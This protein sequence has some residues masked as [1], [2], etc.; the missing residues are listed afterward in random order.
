MIPSLDN[1][2]KFANLSIK[3]PMGKFDANVSYIPGTAYGVDCFDV[4]GGYSNYGPRIDV[5]AP[6]SGI[7]SVLNSNAEYYDSNPTPDP[8]VAQLGLTDT[9]NNN[10]KKMAGTSMASPQICGMLACLAEK[11]PRMTQADARAYLKNMSPETVDYSNMYMSA[12]SLDF[13][14]NP[15]STK[16]IAFFHDTRF[17][18]LEVGGMQ[19]KPFP[20]DNEFQRPTSGA[21]YP[22]RKTINNAKNYTFV[23]SS[24]VERVNNGQTANVIITTIGVA[25]GTLIP[26]IIT[27]KNQIFSFTTG[28][29]NGVCSATGIVPGTNLKCKPNTGTSITTDAT[30]GTTRA[31]SNVLLGAAAL[32]QSTTPTVGTDDDGYWDLDLPF[33]IS[34]LGQTYNK[35][36]LGTN[37]YITFG[38]GS[39][40]YAV[41]VSAPNLPKILITASD[42]K[43]KRIYYGTEGS[44]PNRTFRIRYEGFISYQANSMSEP[45][46]IY[47]VIFYENSPSTIDVQ[48]GENTRWSNT[49][50]EKTSGGDWLAFPDISVPTTG[51]VAV[52]VVNGI[53][54]GVLPITVNTSKTLL[55]NVR[56]N[57]FPTPDVDLI[58][59]M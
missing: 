7:Q 4:R 24:D 20:P 57:M 38:A 56:L 13:Q 22:R 2:T 32:T 1:I 31:I 23:I 8:R 45:G 55:L 29:V 26:Y 44:A 47:E 33:S 18:E 58:L 35:V 12:L 52:S 14:R 15:E 50:I 48:V 3:Q 21:V 17:P 37:S 19:E 16:K 49:K 53:G 42:T 5:F 27:S 11:Y 36:Y 10:F 39:A 34:Y 59:N 25:N 43:T 6:G 46:T 54:T 41:T 28:T 51:T 9:V 40:E 30:S